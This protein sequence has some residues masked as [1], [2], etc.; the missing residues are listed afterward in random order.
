MYTNN[1]ERN[2]QVNSVS[3]DLYAVIITPRHGKSWMEINLL[4]HKAETLVDEVNELS[5]RGSVAI[6]LPMCVIISLEKVAKAHG[7]Q[8]SADVLLSLRKRGYQTCSTCMGFGCID[9]KGLGS[10]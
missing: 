7:E 9:C 10:R 2:A 3:N 8:P 6:S 4:E 5:T 1:A